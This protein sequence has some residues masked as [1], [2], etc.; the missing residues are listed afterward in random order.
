MNKNAIA[1]AGKTHPTIGTRIDG[2][3][4]AAIFWLSLAKLTNLQSQIYCELG[5]DF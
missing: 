5:T 3:N 2:K 4:E 1:T